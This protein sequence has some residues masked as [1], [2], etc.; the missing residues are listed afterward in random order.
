MVEPRKRQPARR[1]V[2]SNQSIQNIIGLKSARSSITLRLTAWHNRDPDA[3][4]GIAFLFNI[5][6]IIFKNDKNDKSG[7]DCSFLANE[8]LK[9]NTLTHM[10]AG[11]KQ[12]SFV[13]SVNVWRLDVKSV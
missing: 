12:H 1:A 2:T 7:S 13:K 3:H 9:R 6:V 10:P 5:F 11:F 4:Q 8:D